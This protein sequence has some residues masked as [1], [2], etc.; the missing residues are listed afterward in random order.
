MS[1]TRPM[2]MMMRQL[3]SL[4]ALLAP[5]A[6]T[7]HG[8]PFILS[9]NAWEQS[10]LDE[11]GEVSFVAAPTIHMSGRTH[12]DTFWMASEEIHLGGHFGNDAWAFSPRVLL[13]GTFDDHVRAVGSKVTVDGEINNGLWAAAMSVSASTGSVLMGD[14]FLLGDTISLL[15]HID[16]NVHA[17]G[18]QVTIGGTVSGDIRVMGDDII[19]RPGTTVAG[20]LIYVTTNLSIVLDAN[21]HVSGELKRVGDPAASGP[22]WAYTL[23]AMVLLFWFGGAVLVGLPFILL[24]PKA[25]GLSVQH[26]RAGLWKCGLAGLALLFGG[27]LLVLAVSFTVIG[28]PLALVLGA[29]YGL[30]LYLGKFPVALVVGSALLRRRG[31]VSLPIALLALVIGLFLYYAVALVPYLGPSLQTAAN[32]FGAGSL[33]LYLAAGRGR[34]GHTNERGEKLSNEK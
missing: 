6:A 32:A 1:R 31:A 12:D 3:L 21:S 26:L 20:D 29:T 19:I 24:F 22:D 13:T 7:A 25:S 8:V 30:L 14:Q 34:I 18:R 2:H 16:G 23:Q 15:G 4:A 27:P 33:I 11:L 5:A 28:I 17:R 10:E 9:T